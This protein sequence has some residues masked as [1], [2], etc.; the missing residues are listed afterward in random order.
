MPSKHA[1]KHKTSNA[2]LCKWAVCKIFE[3]N[4]PQ[5]VC[6]ICLDKPGHYTVT[7][8][9]LRSDPCIA[10]Q[11]RDK[12]IDETQMKVTYLAFKISSL[13]LYSGSDLSNGNPENCRMCFFISCAWNVSESQFFSEHVKYVTI[14]WYLKP[15]PFSSNRF[16]EV[17]RCSKFISFIGRRTNYFLI[18]PALF[19]TKWLFLN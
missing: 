4:V 15:I 1:W 7:D 2:P 10:F 6:V 16:T 14:Y 13:F 12:M 5:T 9:Q 17:V 11:S 19:E 8:W 3:T 18:F